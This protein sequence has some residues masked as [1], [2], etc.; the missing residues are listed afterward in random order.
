MH[1]NKRFA[2]SALAFAVALALVSC[3]PLQ[4]HA[5]EIGVEEQTQIQEYLEAGGSQGAFLDWQ[6]SEDEDGNRNT[7][8]TL[9]GI[10]QLA[11]QAQSDFYEG[12]DFGAAPDTVTVSGSGYSGLYI[13]DSGIYQPCTLYTITGSLL[14]PKTLCNAPDFTVVLQSDSDINYTFVSNSGFQGI[15]YWLSYGYSGRTYRIAT[16]ARP[17]SYSEPNYGSSYV[18]GL[19]VSINTTNQLPRLSEM[20]FSNHYVTVCGTAQNITLPSGT[21]DTSRPWDYYNN[22]VLPYIREEFP[23][24]EDY[25]FFPDGYQPPAQPST[26]PVEYPTLPGF[27][28]ALETNGTEPASDYAYNIPDMPTKDIAVPSFDFSSINPAEVMAPVAEYLRSMWALVTGVLTE[29]GL[30]PYVAIA[31]FAA[32]VAGL[33]HLGK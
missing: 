6:W 4:G 7:R 27:D 26:V 33:L 24:Y 22:V 31:V 19:G 10:Q 5:V 9:Y 18:S 2:L 8:L 25:Y 14:Q 30:F 15:S 17:G 1:N 20:N 32:I 16:G 3:K 12:L 21:V 23:G 11:F 29:F 13:D 28:L